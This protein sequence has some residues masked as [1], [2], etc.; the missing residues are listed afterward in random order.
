M[1]VGS[2]ATV[3]GVLAQ[4]GKRVDHCI[5]RN[6]A[7]HVQAHSIVRVAP[8]PS[9]R[10]RSRRPHACYWRRLAERPILDKPLV[11][12]VEIR[13]FKCMNPECSRRTFSE[14]IH[15]LAGRH[16]RRTRSH[17]KALLALAH[18]LGGEAAARLA[19]ELGLGA[20]S[21]TI[22]AQLHRSD[23]TRRTPEP[24]IVGI[25]DWAIA[26]GH[27]YGTI[28]V[29][30]ERREPIDVL[31]GREATGVADWL[32]AHPSIQ[33]VARDRAD[34]Y[35]EA[36]A[37]ALPAAQQVSDRWHL[38][39]N[40][41]DNVERMLQRLGPQMR[42]AA[43]QVVV[44]E[45]TQGQQGRPWD[46][47]LVAW[48]RLSDDR[49]ALRV[50]QYEKVMVLHGQGGTMKGIARELDIDHRTVRKFIVSG[51]FPERPDGSGH[52][53][54]R[55]PGRRDGGL[56]D[57]P[58]HAGAGAGAGGERVQVADGARAADPLHR[59]RTQRCGPAEAA[60]ACPV[61]SPC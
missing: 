45:T 5:H 18:A 28:V 50:A 43:Q 3:D 4:V 6:G 22:L 41:R 53:A 51:T 37:T 15:A 17:A 54:K 16:Q 31:E 52:A 32:R 24:R 7:L 9:C 14:D 46:G 55:G 48:Q 2:I 1:K 21:D 36:V 59:R 26:R 27:R 8:C 44:D 56:G 38:L 33:I 58:G 61:E 39:A 11:L 35:A 47:G 34:A 13:R 42:Q 12:S 30:L 19:A 20:S 10:R 23:H 57:E 29:D 49:R 60:L 40:L 25:D